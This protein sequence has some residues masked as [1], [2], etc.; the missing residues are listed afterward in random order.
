MSNLDLRMFPPLRLDSLLEVVRLELHDERN[1]S[2]LHWLEAVLFVPKSQYF[3][4]E[5]TCE[6]SQSGRISERIDLID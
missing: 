2:S 6:R 4:S 1:A 3:D 5:R